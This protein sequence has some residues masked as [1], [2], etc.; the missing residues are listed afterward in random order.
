MLSN[1]WDWIKNQWK[2]IFCVL[3][4]IISSIGVAFGTYYA[5]KAIYKATHWY[6]NYS[7][8]FV[9][10]NQQLVLNNDQKA[11]TTL[12][13]LFSSQDKSIS[14]IAE[15]EQYHTL[16]DLHW[17]L[18]TGEMWGWTYTEYTMKNVYF[19]SSN[20]FISSHMNN[21]MNMPADMYIDPDYEKNLPVN[22]INNVLIPTYYGFDFTI[23]NDP[24]DA[25]F[26][27]SFTYWL[28]APIIVDYV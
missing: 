24:K 26:S 21:L 10:K 28:W 22:D 1:L 11:T 12:E 4:T 23:D 5:Y 19:H 27:F 9:I 8:A 15:H 7:S 2:N 14:A 25:L 13:D 6:R 3:L 18:N 16:I 20:Q 17:T